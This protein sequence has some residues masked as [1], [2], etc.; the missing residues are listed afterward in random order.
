[1]LKSAFRA[2]VSRHLFPPVLEAYLPLSPHLLHLLP[3]DGAE[4]GEGKI[5]GLSYHS[6]IADVRFGELNRFN[7]SSI[8]MLGLLF[9]ND[10]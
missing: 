3:A 4:D 8:V 7:A 2:L 9:V 1:M 5:K 6:A 10:A